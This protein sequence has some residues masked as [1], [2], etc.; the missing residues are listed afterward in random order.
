M[1]GLPIW[2][3]EDGYTVCQSNSIL[4]MLGQRFGYYTEDDCD[5]AADQAY[6]ID[7][8][9]DFYEDLMPTIASFI[10]PA[11]SLYLPP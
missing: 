7:S 8:L 9:C 2:E 11:V 10:F 6:E 5:D 1:G 4:R 3:D